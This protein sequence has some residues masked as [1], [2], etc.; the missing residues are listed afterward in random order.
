MSPTTACAAG[1][2]LTED[3]EPQHP[4]AFGVQKHTSKPKFEEEEE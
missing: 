4:D 3:V 2:I 1:G